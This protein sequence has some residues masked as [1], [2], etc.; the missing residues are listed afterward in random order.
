MIEDGVYDVFI[1]DVED[2]DDEGRTRFD[3]TITS[4]P[5]KGE[6]VSLNG[7]GLRGDAIEVIGLPGVLRVHD[8]HPHLEIE[9]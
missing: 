8:G 4:G 2:S 7:L 6:V 1:V 9:R 3:L 5:H